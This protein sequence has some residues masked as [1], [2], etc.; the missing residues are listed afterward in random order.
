MYVSVD[1]DSNA[2]QSCVIDITKMQES[3]ASLLQYDESI[4]IVNNPSI[5]ILSKNLC[6]LLALNIPIVSATV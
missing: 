1:G 3:E 2:D 6:V 4:G 5:L